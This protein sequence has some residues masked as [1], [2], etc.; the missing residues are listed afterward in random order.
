[1]ISEKNKGQF[2]NYYKLPVKYLEIMNWLCSTR[3]YRKTFL[4][5]KKLYPKVKENYKFVDFEIEK[6]TLE[7][8]EII[9][10]GLIPK[11]QY[12][13]EKTVVINVE[14][15]E[16]IEKSYIRRGYAV[17]AYASK[18]ISNQFPLPRYMKKRL[19]E[20]LNRKEIDMLH[21]GKTSIYIDNIERGEAMIKI[22]NREQ[23]VY[24]RQVN[25][26]RKKINIKLNKKLDE[27]IKQG[28]KLSEYKLL[29]NNKCDIMIQ[30]QYIIE[31]IPI[32]MLKYGFTDETV[33]VII[34]PE[35]DELIISKDG[36][37]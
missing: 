24:L 33:F 18:V 16:N 21:I 32:D 22:T 35:I 26:E 34:K 2:E 36:K 28:K 5:R 11:Y 13:H 37:R 7:K 20:L 6:G 8:P 19:K 9:K 12:D 31:T 27:L 17:G 30:P 25:D 29:V 4:E 15:I 3:F 23:I 14:N 10:I 1:M